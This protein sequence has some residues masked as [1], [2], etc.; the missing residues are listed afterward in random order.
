MK[1]NDGDK[2]LVGD[3]VS[4]DENH[5]GVVVANIES[6]DFSESYPKDQWEY[7]KSGV[8]IDT[9]FGGL[10]HYEQEAII[11]DGVKLKFRAK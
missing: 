2:I 1:Y 10:I 7:L 4:I 11:F 8:L 6:G 3:K 9:D 5:H